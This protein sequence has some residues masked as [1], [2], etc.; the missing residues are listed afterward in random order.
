[1]MKRLWS[2][3]SVSVKSKFPF[4]RGRKTCCFA[5]SLRQTWT[6]KM[7][8][9]M[10]PILPI[11]SSLGY[12]AIIWGSFGGPRRQVF[13]VLGRSRC[14]DSLSCDLGTCPGMYGRLEAPQPSASHKTCVAGGA[15]LVSVVAGTVDVAVAHS[16]ASKVEAVSLV[17]NYRCSG[18]PQGSK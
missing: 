12:W 5:S 3:V 6:S 7:A 13:W 15:H 18:C 16:W 2:F 8:K 17:L 4:D 14:L 9:I 10:D 11:L 1:M